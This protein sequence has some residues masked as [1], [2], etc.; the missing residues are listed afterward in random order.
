MFHTE[1]HQSANQQKDGGILLPLASQKRTGWCLD[2][3]EGTHSNRGEG[4]KV[5]RKKNN[6][7][8]FWITSDQS[9]CQRERL[10]LTEIPGIKFFH[11]WTHIPI[12]PAGLSKA[13]Q[14]NLAQINS[15]TVAYGRKAI[16]SALLLS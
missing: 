10:S 9:R 15:L 14:V 8:I 11:F 2:S 4:I 7:I 3:Q 12:A 16:C 6:Q 13:Q 5:G 1:T